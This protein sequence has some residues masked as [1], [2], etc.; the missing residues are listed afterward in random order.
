MTDVLQHPFIGL[1]L[2]PQE[3]GDRRF[4]TPHIGLLLLPQEEGVTGVGN[5]SLRRLL[6][7]FQKDCP[8]T[9]RFRGTSEDRW[10]RLSFPA[11]PFPAVPVYK[12]H[13]P[14]GVNEHFYQNN[15][16]RQ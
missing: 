9:E 4:S 2:L 8:E 14:K 10:R 12:N 6:P 3:D 13:L 16:I 5:S 1:L 11:S 7:L 15:K